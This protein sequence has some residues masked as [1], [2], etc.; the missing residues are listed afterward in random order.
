MQITRTRGTLALVAALTFAA[1]GSSA[2]PS[3]AAT[4]APPPTAAPATQA[5][6]TPAV[7]APPATPA[8]TAPP[9]T[10]APTPAATPEVTA[11]PASSGT[12]ALKIGVVTDVGRVDDKNF[13]QYSFEGAKKGAADVGSAEPQVVVP[14]TADEYASDIQQFVTQKYDVIVT[15]GF[16]LYAATVAAALANKDIWFIGVDQSIC[17]DATGKDDPTFGC[18]GDPKTLLP[19]YIGI[20]FQE[21]QAGYLAGIVA[22]SVSKTDIIGA[23]GGINLVPAVVRYIQG[24]ELGAKATDP[25][26]TVK[27]GYVSADDFGKAFADPP[28]GQIY[29]TS[30]IQANKP[31][32]LFQVAGSTGNGVLHAAC[33]AGILGIGVDV[34][35]WGSLSAATDPTYNCIVTSAEK[36]LSNAVEDSIKQISAGTAAGGNVEFN[37][38][39]DGIGVSAEQ[40]GKGLITADIQAKVDAAIAAMKAT[41]P[42]TTCPE[43]CGQP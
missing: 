21:D 4:V 28:G 7:T 31:D 2:T 5:P 10:T 42:L 6:A 13:N 3:P 33:A 27:T 43:K 32:V 14:A 19:H 25:N 29:G 17:I 16:N 15:V 20:S 37:A 36:H 35:Q 39:N 24:Y 22:A 18:A 30:F 11:P 38:N 1:C 40:D 34:D 23:I 9:A 26:V 41:P 8:V 12:G